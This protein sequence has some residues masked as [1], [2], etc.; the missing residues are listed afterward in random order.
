ME[1][2]NRISTLERRRVILEELRKNRQIFIPELSRRFG[3]SEVTLR[4]DLKYLENRNLLI[5]SRGG[6]MCPVQIGDDLP[7]ESRQVMHIRQ[8]KDIAARAADL[9][10]DGDTILL[11]SGTTIMQLAGLL[12]GKKNLTVITNALDI[13]VRVATFEEVKLIVPGG[14][15]RRKSH[16]L[17]GAM[18]LNGLGVFRADKYFV[19]ADGLTSEGLFTSNLEEGEL[20]R[21]IISHAKETIALVDESKMGRT[22]QMNFADLDAISV[23]V[24]NG[25]VPKHILDALAQT[26]GLVLTA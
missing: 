15:F 6:A 2:P 19:S 23:L 9:I 1:G 25:A 8:K 21:T 24:T 14:V 3:V 18:A 12:G 4:K 7:V 17:V 16:S 11:D 5:R 22:G 26:G 20:A 10:E 13:A